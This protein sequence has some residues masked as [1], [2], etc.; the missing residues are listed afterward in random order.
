MADE[1]QYRRIASGDLPALVGV[2]EQIVEC[3]LNQTFHPHP[4]DEETARMVATNAG[5][6][7]YYLLSRRETALAYGMLRGWNEGFAVPSLGICV[8]P[9]AQKQGLGEKFMRFLHE[10]AAACGATRIRLK[11]AKTNLRAF[12]LYLRMGYLF[13]EE[14][15]DSLV[16]YL[17]LN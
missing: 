17:D 12:N 9:Q 15:D 3:G 5:A 13:G 16:G 2:F 4:F 8:L 10:E 11:V 14:T 1:I 7:R 6:D